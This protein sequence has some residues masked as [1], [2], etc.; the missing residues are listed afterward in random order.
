MKCTNTPSYTLFTLF[1]FFVR[2]TG[3]FYI[4]QLMIL[5]CYFYLSY[6]SIGVADTAVILLAAIIKV[7]VRLRSE[8]RVK[9]MAEYVGVCDVLRDG[10]WVC[11]LS[12]ADLV[13]GDVI[14]V[15]SQQLVPVDA[16][17]LKGDIV[18]DESSLTGKH[19]GILKLFL[20]KKKNN[21][22]N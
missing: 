3:F 22:Q 16:V 7:F 4:Y 12:S 17:L 13:P 14:R 1:P 20:Y 18:T 9:S 2:L 5:W 21:I 11:G 6:W 8:K 15:N 10:S 19:L